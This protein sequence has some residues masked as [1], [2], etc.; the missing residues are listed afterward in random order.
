MKIDLNNFD[1]FEKRHN[2]PSSIEIE[3]MLK[4]IGVSSVDELI[5]KTIPENIRLKQPLNLP[6]AQGEHDFL[7]SFKELASKNKI[8]KSYIGM[9]YHDCYV[10]NVILRN[11]LE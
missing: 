8:F 9:G 5:N 11:I 2:S 3:E 1:R 7:K 6:K 10:P 4:S